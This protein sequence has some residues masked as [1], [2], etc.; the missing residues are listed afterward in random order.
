[1]AAPTSVKWDQV[2]FTRGQFDPRVQVRTDYPYYYKAAKQITNCICIPQGG[3]TRRWGTEVVDVCNTAALDYANVELY[4]MSYDDVTY[5]LLWE[6]QKLTIYL[7][8]FKVI[9]INN[10]IYA[11]EDIPNLRFSQVADR[12]IIT[13]GY[14]SPQV[15]KHQD[16][17]ALN[18]VTYN[19]DSGIFTVRTPAPNPPTILNFL[20]V[21]LKIGTVLPVKFGTNPTDIMPKTSP[22]IFVGRTYFINIR[23]FTAPPPQSTIITFQVFSSSE[24][25]AALINP[26]KILPQAVNSLSMYIVNVWIMQPVNFINKPTYDFNADYFSPNI[27]F[28]VS[29]A[30]SVGTTPVTVTAVGYSGFTQALVGGIFAGNGGVLRIRNFVSPTVI[31]G[32][33]LKP[34]IADSDGGVVTITGDMAFIGEPAWSDNRGWPKCSSYYQNRMIYAN[35]REIP[36]GQ[37]LSVIN[38]TYDFD[39]GVETNA[40]DG[41]SSYPAGGSGGYIQ[42]ITSARSLLI[43]TNKANY[44]TSIQNEQ[45]IT[46]S[47]YMLVEHNK[48]GVGKLAPVY[49]DNQV[50]F[51]DTSGNNVITMTWDFIQGNYVTNSVSIAA[52]SLVKNPIDMTAFA[53]PK[54]LD[55]FY[56]IFINSDGTGCVLQTLKEEDILAFSLINTNTHLVAGQNNES[57]T[58]PSLYR[59][60]ASSQNRVWFL[61][62][63]VVLQPRIGTSITF[64]GISASDKSFVTPPNNNLTINSVYRCAFISNSANSVIPVTTPAMGN[65]F[66]YIKAIEANKVRIFG[67]LADAAA[68][69]N[70]FVPSA[71]G[72]NYSITIYDEV[73]KLFMEEVNFNYYTDMSY[74]Y[75]SP[76]NTTSI[77]VAT[78]NIASGYLNGQVVQVVGDDNVL[79]PRTVFANRI[80][81]ERPSNVIKLGLSYTSTLIPLPPVIPEQPGMLFSPT[82]IRTLYISYYNTAGATVQG[83]GIPTQTLNQVE[84]GA[85]AGVNNGLGVFNYAPMEGW[86]GVTGSDL[87]ISQNQ[88]LPMTITGLSYIIDI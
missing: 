57:V 58:M 87:I 27:K 75:T 39:D 65:N 73:H 59:K 25:A 31:N 45:I 5:L 1:M 56:V 66:Y 82:H 62:D 35:T 63:R 52:S 53:E 40:D 77:T 36:N 7:E 86:G 10:L 28:T 24:D 49:I 42:S 11:K 9:T 6:T 33:T 44:S 19:V 23:S 51:V 16:S 14:H 34:F 30:Q 60:V 37:W 68:N 17:V 85:N 78:G 22:Q 50:F 55:G 21:G 26:Y 54:Y 8:G 3:V 74:Q 81:I 70:V 12:V 2:N 38:N 18:G 84:I 64:I 29:A 41:I 48:F 32:V 83:Y 71:I 79:Q 43:H 61:V 46:P 69:I 80:T 67:S 88:P 76:P 4:A 15:L 72:S 47:T 20:P 13:D